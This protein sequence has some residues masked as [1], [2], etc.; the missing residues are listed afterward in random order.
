[1]PRKKKANVEI[2]SASETH[3]VP[4][5]QAPAV[6]LQAMLD[7]MVRERV[8][9][10]L[11]MRAGGHVEPDFQPR[12]VANDARIRNNVFEIRKWSLFFEKWGCRTCHRKNVA[13]A[14]SG[15]C[16][17]CH[18]LVAQRLAA[19]KRD[20]YRDDPELEIERQINQIT[21]RM[22]SAQAL[23]GDVEK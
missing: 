11:A 10:I 17:R 22:R 23:L 12:E 3:L 9:E 20:F 14:S 15:C 4:L 7:R 19:I 16:A 21:S 1:M 2:V 5:V 13:H 18:N 8:D 6:N